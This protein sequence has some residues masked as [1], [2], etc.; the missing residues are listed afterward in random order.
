MCGNELTFRMGLF[1]SIMRAERKGGR[2]DD[3]AVRLCRLRCCLP[4]VAVDTG[5]A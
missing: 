1:V 4:V 2:D 5:A 3:A